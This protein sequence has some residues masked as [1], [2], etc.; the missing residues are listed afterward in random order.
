MMHVNQITLAGVCDVCDRRTQEAET[1]EAQNIMHLLEQA[2]LD[3]SDWRRANRRLLK[4]ALDYAYKEW[5]NKPIGFVGYG[6]AGS[7]WTRALKA[8]R[9]TVDPRAA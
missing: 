4:N 7:W 2:G 8:A 1:D 3:V 9:E 5:G 6:G